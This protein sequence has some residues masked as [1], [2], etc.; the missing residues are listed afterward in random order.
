M[1]IMQ[2]FIF[3]ASVKIFVGFCCTFTHYSDTSCAQNIQYAV[4]SRLGTVNILPHNERRV[5]AF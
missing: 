5:K 2:V 4:I 1:T 3:T